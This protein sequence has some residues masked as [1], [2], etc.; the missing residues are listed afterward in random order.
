MYLLSP[1]DPKYFKPT[2]MQVMLSDYNADATKKTMETRRQEMLDHV[3]DKLVSHCSKH[4]DVLLKDKAGCDLFFE[5][6]KASN[7]SLFFF[8]GNVTV[9]F[10]L[11]MR[12]K[13]S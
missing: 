7:G 10:S 11:K 1:R 6:T 3:I 8:C 4:A 9:N 2:T 5:V 13:K 12:I